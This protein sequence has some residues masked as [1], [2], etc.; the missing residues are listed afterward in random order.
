MQDEAVNNQVEQVETV[1]THQ[2]QKTD[3]SADDHQKE[4]WRVMRERVEAAERRALELERVMQENFSPHKASHKIEIE[5]DEDDDPRRLK[6]EITQMRD[7]MDAYKKR[8]AEVMLRAQFNDFTTVV[9]DENIRKLAQKDRDLY[10]LIYTSNDIYERGINAYKL[11]KQSGIVAA[12]L[13]EPSQQAQRVQDNK[14][15]PRSASNAAPQV[16]ESTLSRFGGGHDRR[17]ISEDR[18]DMLRRQVAEAKKYT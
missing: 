4:N 15:R 10:N 17:V 13:P 16:G 11:I 2:E 9:N 1:N 8:S 12:A 3:Q 6:K 5:D 7:D 14:M 18:K